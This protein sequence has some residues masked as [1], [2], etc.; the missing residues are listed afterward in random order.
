MLKNKYDI[1]NLAKEF[2]LFH[3]DFRDKFIIFRPIILN[4]KYCLIKL[5]ILY[6]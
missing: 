6:Y 2:P 4:K 1:Y 5:K 3:F